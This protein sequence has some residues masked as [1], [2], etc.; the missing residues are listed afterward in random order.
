[1]NPIFGPMMQVTDE[2]SW[3]KVF[4]VNVKSHFFLVRECLPHMR[5]GSAVLIISS[6]AGS[7]EPGS[8]GRQRKEHATRSPSLV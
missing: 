3:D 7:V 2:K 8:A 4:D 1:V 5:E 6:Y